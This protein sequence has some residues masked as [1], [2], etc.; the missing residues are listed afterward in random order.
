VPA[1]HL[2]ENGIINT[3]MRK[4]YADLVSFWDVLSFMPNEIDIDTKASFI[5]YID[6]IH[7]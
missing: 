1:C 3:S 4:C 7:F 5:T 6:Q 2:G